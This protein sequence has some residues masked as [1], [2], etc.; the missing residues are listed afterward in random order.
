MTRLPVISALALL[1]LLALAVLPAPAEVYNLKVV[2]DANPD[3]SD[4]A[5]MI[6]S[7]TAKWPTTREKCWAMYYWTHIARRQTSPMVLHGRELGDPIRQ[8]NDYGYTM[9]STVAGVNC[10]IWHNMGLPVKFWD[11]SMHTVSECFYDDRWHIY[12]NSM[13]AIYT[14]CDG[15][16]V[17]GVQDV[18]KE[19][20]CEASGGR[21]EP[22]HIAKYHC[23]YA[24]SNNG[25][26]TGADCP[27]D[28]QQEYICFNPN[29]LKYR[30]YECGWEDGHRYI[31]NLRDGD[32]YTRY[33]Y[34]LDK[35][36][37]GK[38]G[39]PVKGGKFLNAITG[40]EVQT[41]RFY[42]PN[43]GEDP[44]AKPFDPERG[45]NIRGNGVWTF[46]PPLTADA[47]KKAIISETN[48]AP[49]AGCGLMA[50]DTSK[51]AE[52]VFKVNAAN[53]VTS[54]RIQTEFFG[55]ADVEISTNNGITWTKTAENEVD[56]VNEHGKRTY[57]LLKEV[58][59]A[60]ELLIKV[61][62][63]AGKLN[64]S[65]SGGALLKSLDAELVTQVNAKTQPKLNIGKNTIYVGAGDQTE[66]IVLW[67][68]NASDKTY[69]EL[70]FEEK[71][72]ACG[73]SNWAYYGNLHPADGK[74]EAY[75]VYKIDAPGE[76]TAVTMGGR[77]SNR[78]SGNHVDMLYS[79]DGGR[80]WTQAWSL[81]SIEP[82]FDTIHQERIAI[83][84]GP[85]SVLFKYLMTGGSSIHSMRME[86]D[87]KPADTTFKPVEVTF[88]WNE[89]QADRTLVKRSHTQLVES[90]PATY[91]INVGG[92]DHP[93]MDSLT[94]N[95]KGSSAATQ[96]VKY[97]Y[98]DG[99]DNADAKK[100][101]HR[102]V[103]YG[104][105]F[106]EGKKYTLSTPSADAW[107]AG[108]K[109]GKKLTDGVVG[110]NYCGGPAPSWGI[111]WNPDAKVDHNIDLDLG[112]SHKC[113]AFR[114]QITSG[115]PWPE[116]VLRGD[117]PD[118]VE[119]L[120]SAD[121]KEYAS[122]GMFNLGLWYKDIAINYMLPDNEQLTGYNFELILPKPVDCRYVR[123]KVTP[124]HGM[125]ITEVQAMDFIKYDPFDIRL[126][127]PNEKVPEPA[128]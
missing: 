99:K 79:I 111:L 12:D 20:A 98:S 62:M 123:Y 63:A 38:D 91:E 74:S 94:V 85:K 110:A 82:P 44:K 58:N 57:L 54:A 8:F 84:G 83:S 67:P 17:A 61:R 27:R 36:E 87:Y 72:I 18:G 3:Y 95:L 30:N 15:K 107:G 80:N 4:M 128:K 92:A 16:T 59:G 75:L 118:K 103:T 100:Y 71:N 47:Y 124:G 52:V 34:R 120:T 55:K 114:I 28:L 40:Q 117:F 25:F 10:A 65:P 127:L 5:S 68:N 56:Q 53:V 22:G 86:A 89:R 126:A 19:G 21:K 77:F 66:S 97:G 37:I 24:T 108:D 125:V 32:S 109:E 93:V 70:V 51:E 88:A 69:K 45:F 6:R 42:I 105:N 50:V 41:E 39:Q 60:Y 14:L 31:L 119:L 122:Q 26:L 81:T 121:G 13:S 78:G 46:R 7:I 115:W 29:G 73:F 116:A 76:I 64:R 113:G 9:C 43:T 48:I 112:E 1:V 49:A 35:P 106:A 2:T 11:I 90:L 101:V 104:K 23:L 96:P 33:Y 102:W